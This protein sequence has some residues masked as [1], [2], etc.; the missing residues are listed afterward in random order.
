VTAASLARYASVALAASSILVFHRE[1]W[2]KPISISTAFFAVAA[3]MIV[4]MLALAARGRRFTFDSLPDGRIVAVIP[5]FNEDPATLRL[6]ILSLLDGTVVPDR[7]HVVDDGSRVPLIP[8]AHPRVEWHRQPNR[9]KRAAQ[10][11]GLRT[12]WNA[13]F[14]LTMDSDSI[15]DRR[16]LEHAL[17]AFTNPI[18]QAVTATCVVRNRS[19]SLLTRLTDL[20]IV[21]GNFVMRRARSVLGVV[22][23]TSGPFALYRARVLFDNAQDYLASGTY[24]DDRRLTHY[25]LLRGEVVACDEAVVEMEMPANVLGVFHQRTRW[26]Q[27]YFRYLGWELQHL[28]GPALYLRVWN[29]VLVVIYPVVVTYALLVVPLVHGFVF[30]EAWAYWITLLY[31]QTLH[32]LAER[33]GMRLRDRFLAW[34]LL[35]PLLVVLQMAIVRPA[36]YMSLTKLRSL[37]W[38]TRDTVDAVGPGLPSVSGNT[39]LAQTGRGVAITREVTIP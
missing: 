24:G 4:L 36:M 25:A 20:E 11:F 6:A 29:L 27:G 14:V 23:P 17:R 18:V 8:F 2:G 21:T 33:P 5:A 37:A 30:W 28:S 12:S 34:L 13:D 39:P 19:Q 31:A 9:G 3:A 35:T 22:A 1:A 15:A 16:A 38:V 10:L 26:F 32:Y 7:I